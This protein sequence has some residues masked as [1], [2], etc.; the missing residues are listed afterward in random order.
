MG[1]RPP[2]ISV[3]VASLADQLAETA[4]LWRPVLAS[5][6]WD[7]QSLLEDMKLRP[8][9]EDKSAPCKVM[10]HSQPH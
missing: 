10:S 3:Y 1:P 9:E 5:P 4:M 2:H 7:P 8:N 6:S